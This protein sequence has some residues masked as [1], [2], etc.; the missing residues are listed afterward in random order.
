TLYHAWFAT[1]GWLDDGPPTETALRDAAAKIRKDLP[2]N[3]WG[4]L[5]GFLAQFRTWLAQPALQAVLMRAAYSDP[6]HSGFPKALLPR[7]RKS[8]APQKVEQ[9]RRFI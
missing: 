5:D 7:W 2:A 9:E 4:A 1:I 6:R 3:T 8:A